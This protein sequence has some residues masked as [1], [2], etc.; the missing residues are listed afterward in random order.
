MTTRAHWSL[1]VALVAAIAPAAFAQPSRVVD[2]DTFFQMESVS[3][4]SISPDGR[5]VVFTRSSVDLTKDQTQGNLW[6]VDVETKLANQL[7]LDGGASRPIWT[8]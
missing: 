6:I 7:T 4:P 1:A 5:Q 3:A 2:K 8:R